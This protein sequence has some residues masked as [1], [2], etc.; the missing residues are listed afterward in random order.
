MTEVEMV[1]VTAPAKAAAPTME[2]PP[3]EKLVL[4]SKQNEGSI[5]LIHM[6]QIIFNLELKHFQ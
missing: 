3:E 4:V 5:W 6:F 2:Y 1:C